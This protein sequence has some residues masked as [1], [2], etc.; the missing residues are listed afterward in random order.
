M[1]NVCYL[2]IMGGIVVLIALLSIPSLFWP[3]CAACKRRT[4]VAR[5]TCAAC[6][7]PMRDD[8]DF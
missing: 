3:K 6:G 8:L 5:D 1:I 2:A 4:W 7:A